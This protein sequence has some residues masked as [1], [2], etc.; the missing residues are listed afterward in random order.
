MDSDCEANRPEDREITR[1]LYG[2]DHEMRLRQEIVLGRG[3]NGCFRASASIRRA[4]TSTK[5]TRPSWCSS[6]SA[7]WWASRSDVRRSARVRARDDR[8]HDHTPVRPGTIASAR[9]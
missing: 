2:G 6:A 8:V 5:G 1:Q 3:G 7:A 4:S 9:T